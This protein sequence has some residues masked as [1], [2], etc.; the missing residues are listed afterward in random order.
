M[1]KLTSE[2]HP[3]VAVVFGRNYYHALGGGGGSCI[4]PGQGPAQLAQQGGKNLETAGSS[5]SSDGSIAWTPLNFDSED[6]DGPTQIVQ[7][8]ASAQ[9]TVFLTAKGRVYQSG[10]LHGHVLPS[11]TRVTIPLP[12]PAT[13]VSCGRHYC[14]A[15]MKGGV[16]VSWGAGHFGQLGIGAS[17]DGGGLDSSD[18]GQ[19]AAAAASLTFAST[20]VVIERLLPHIIGSPVVK[21]AAGGTLKFRSCGG[22]PPRLHVCSKHV[23]N[24]TGT[25]SPLPNRDASGR[26]GA[27]GATSAGASQRR[28]APPRRPSPPPCRSR[29]KAPRW[30]LQRA[31]RTP[32]H[33][34]PVCRPCL[35]QVPPDKSLR[36]ARRT[37]DSAASCAE[38]ELGLFPPGSSRG[39]LRLP[40]RKYLRLE[41]TPW[42]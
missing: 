23:L 40:S 19:Q 5:F 25:L 2:S 4:V 17:A 29:W 42:R 32:S 24:Q 30:T 35:R 38:P 11:P 13:Q 22:L 18:H 36:G 41:T 6:G 15:L 10:T 16:V 1:K 3:S 31:D 33:S 26:G 21:V 37:T 8:D 14:L 39:S 34:C 7:V 20:P 28:P 12:I 27:T 9:S